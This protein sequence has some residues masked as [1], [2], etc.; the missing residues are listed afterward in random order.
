M[1]AEICFWLISEFSRVSLYVYVERE[2]I[3]WKTTTN[4]TFIAKYLL[5]MF[6]KMTQSQKMWQILQVYFSRT[7]TSHLKPRYQG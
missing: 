1:I 2:G 7:V 6:Y 4:A 3:K 5:R